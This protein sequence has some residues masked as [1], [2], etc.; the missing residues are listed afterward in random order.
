MNQ[1]TQMTGIQKRP[2]DRMEKLALAREI[3]KRIRRHD[4][5]ARTEDVKSLCELVEDIAAEESVH[6]LHD[7]SVPVLP[8]WQAD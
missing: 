3:A 5:N 4:T 7:A 1:V 8:L 2:V 6:E